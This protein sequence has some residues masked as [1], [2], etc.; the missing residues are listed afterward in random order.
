[1][2][3]KCKTK[4]N[5]EM[6]STLNIFKKVKGQTEGGD[7]RTLIYPTANSVDHLLVGAY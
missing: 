5:I 1:M 3:L 6:L 4:Y 7:K 2:Y